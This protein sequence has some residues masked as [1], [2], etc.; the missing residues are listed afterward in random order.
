MGDEWWFY[1]GGSFLYYDW[2][3][4]FLEGINELEVGD[5]DCYVWYVL[6]MVKLRREGIV[7]FD[8]FKQWEGYVIMCLVM[9]DGD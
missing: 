4:G 2:W 3:I 6:G 9:F 7:S 8:G 1:Y 5:L